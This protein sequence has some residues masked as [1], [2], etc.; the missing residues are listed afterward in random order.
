ME[1]IV[2]GIIAYFIWHFSKPKRKKSDE[3]PIKLNIETSFDRNAFS[4]NTKIDTGKLTKQ[5]DGEYSINPKS[6]FPLTINNCTNEDAQKIKD[7]L[8]GEANW[9]RNI[10]EISYLIAQSNI[11][12]LELKS[13]I[14][15][16]KLKVENNINQQIESSN[17]WDNSSEKDKN[18]LVSGFRK[19]AINSLNVKPS[20]DNCLEILIFNAPSDVTAD[21]ELILLFSGNKE[22]Y[23][24]YLS[25]LGRSTKAIKVSTDDY[26]RK[27][28]EELSKVG[29]A[30]RGKDI[31]V[32]ALLDGLRLK[33]INEYFSDR[34]EKKLTRKTKAID[35]AIKQPDVLDV[36]SKHI[37]FREMFQ[38]ADPKNININEIKKCYQYATAQAEIIRDTYVAGYRTL[39]T[40]SEFKDA[41]YDG[42]EIEANDC[43]SHCNKLNGKKTKRKPSKLPPY[44]LGCTC[45]LEGT[46]D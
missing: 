20:R 19:K 28:W 23:R 36:L 41:E 4:S 5:K 10:E 26:R 40:L 25:N 13:F 30:N 6:P 42:W 35:F 9:E 8:D 2:I 33:D 15:D 38:L 17:E 44:H 37:S 29:L 27:S 11:E 22:L 46:Y 24:F 12:C 21:D 14:S 16:L 39:R 34:L 31:S 32:E 7:L 18:D 45:S 3:I 1:W 43:C